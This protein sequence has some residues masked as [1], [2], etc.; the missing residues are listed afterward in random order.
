MIGNPD[1]T[2]LCIE[3]YTLYIFFYITWNVSGSILA[4][5]VNILNTALVTFS[6]A[7]DKSVGP[8]PLAL[9]SSRKSTLYK[10]GITPNSSV[11]LRISVNFLAVAPM[12]KLCYIV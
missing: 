7:V 1:Y 10:T 3:Y 2:T 12:L 6:T 9:Q 5:D 8:S 4:I 11:F